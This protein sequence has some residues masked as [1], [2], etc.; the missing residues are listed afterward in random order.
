MCFPSAHKE[1]DSNEQIFLSVL[2]NGCSAHFVKE[3]MSGSK[4]GQDESSLETFQ[5]TRTVL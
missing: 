5:K 1:R 2:V 3:L 4:K